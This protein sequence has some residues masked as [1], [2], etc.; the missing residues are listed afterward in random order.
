VP[1]PPFHICTGKFEA[2]AWIPEGVK[3]RMKHAR[4]SIASVNEQGGSETDVIVVGRSRG[5]NLA[6]HEER[7]L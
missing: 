7:E 3:G 5:R 1:A 4:G 2:L 6:F